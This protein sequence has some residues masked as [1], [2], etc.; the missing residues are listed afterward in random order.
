MDE[1]GK[2]GWVGDDDHDDVE[3]IWGIHKGI[4]A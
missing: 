1:R 2:G 3:C 4:L